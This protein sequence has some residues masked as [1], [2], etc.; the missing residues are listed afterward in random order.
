MLGACSTDITSVTFVFVYQWRFTTMLFVCQWLFTTM[1]LSVSDFLPQSFCL[2]VTF[3]HSAFVCQWLFTA[4]LLSASDLLPQCFLSVIDFLPQCFYCCCCSTSSGI[5]LLF[6]DWSECA[7]EC[8]WH[9]D[10]TF[11][12]AVPLILGDE[13]VCC[14]VGVVVVAVS[15]THLTLPTNHRV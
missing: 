5:T 15:Y 14:T 11:L 6:Y 13:V 2:S 12:G 9:H 4:M 10:D 3:Y 7:S 1:L 8:T